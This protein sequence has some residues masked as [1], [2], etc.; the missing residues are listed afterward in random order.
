MFDCDEA[1]TAG[2]REALWFF[3]ERQLGVRLVCSPSMQNS[4]FKGSQ[5]ESISRSKIEELLAH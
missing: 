3:V 5:P 2:A 1:G 4:E